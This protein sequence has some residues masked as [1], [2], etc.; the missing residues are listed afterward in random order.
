MTVR[1]RSIMHFPRR[2]MLAY[3]LMKAGLFGQLMLFV[4][5]GRLLLRLKAEQFVRMRIRLPQSQLNEQ[6]LESSLVA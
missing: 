2:D 1:L 4:T 5:T 6:D 3:G